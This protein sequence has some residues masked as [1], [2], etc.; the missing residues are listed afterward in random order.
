MAAWPR[1]R[2]S[3]R[4]FG[5]HACAAAAYQ[6][7]SVGMG[8]SNGVL[9]RRWSYGSGAGVARRELCAAMATAELRELCGCCCEDERPRR[10]EN[11]AWLSAGGRWHDEG[12]LGRI[13]AWLGR[14]EATRGRFSST[15]WPRPDGGRPPIGASSVDS[16]KQTEPDDEFWC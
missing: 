7:R 14:A 6:V 15:W 4:N 8:R 10:S 3:R 13:V 11:G 12:A 1:R 16:E 9:G 2:G 5:E